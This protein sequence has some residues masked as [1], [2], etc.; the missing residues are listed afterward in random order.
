MDDSVSLDGDI[1]STEVGIPE[2]RFIY[3]I[4]KRFTPGLNQTICEDGKCKHMAI[5]I[6]SL[7]Q[8]P[9]FPELEATLE[10]HP[11]CKL[12]SMKTVRHLFISLSAGLLEIFTNNFT[13]CFRSFPK[14]IWSLICTFW[15]H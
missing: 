11:K 1:R 7:D 14:T 13:I 8:R 3:F 6:H 12:M 2:D 15:S 4:R 10:S 9:N 5:R